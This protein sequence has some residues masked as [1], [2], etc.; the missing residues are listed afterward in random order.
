MGLM[1]WL[2]G[3]GRTE[4]SAGTGSAGAA[5]A[6]APRER[7]DLAELPPIQRMLGGQ[8]LVI[9][10]SGFQGALATRQDTSLGTPLGHLVSP[11]APTGLVHGITAPAPA[12]SPSPVQRSVERPGEPPVCTGYVPLSVPMPVQ[13]A[14]VSGAP[15]M[16]SAGESAVA[17]LPVRRLV[18]EQPLVTASGTGPVAES[19]GP[20]PVPASPVQRSAL[21]PAPDRARRAPGLGAPM[22]ALPPTAQRKAAH[23]GPETAGAGGGAGEVPGG[24]EAPEAAVFSAPSGVPESAPDTSGATAPLLGDSP[25]LPAAS[26]PVPA[27]PAPAVQRS[28]AVSFPGPLAPPRTSDPVAPLLAERPVALQ[29]GPGGGVGAVQRSAVD[30]AEAEAEAAAGVPSAGTGAVPGPS[31]YASPSAS[32]SGPPDSVPVRWTSDRAGVPSVTPAASLPAALQRTATAPAPG[33][34]ART[35]YP[36]RPALQRQA[37]G[38][39]PVPRSLPGSGSRSAPATASAPSVTSTSFTTAGSAAVAAGVAQRMADG[40]VVFGSPPPSYSAP[41]VQRETE[42]E[43]PPPPD[44]PQDAAPEPEPEPEPGPT[45]EAHG[46]PGA[47]G[48]APAHG[49]APVVTDELVRA[50]YAPLSRLFKADLRLERERAGF[51]INTRH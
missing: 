13:R 39:P 18:G 25:L 31:S 37:V 24:G 1:S 9:D 47:S 17:E 15:A 44:P 33:E 36:S 50:L 35:S 16:T 14:A 28:S 49:G 38:G 4:T 43:E 46:A 30:G 32:P 34:A 20:P 8:D 45:A 2:R 26:E 7:V 23:D 21:P 6:A 5:P 3:G 19:S 40:S 29:A 42:S 12:E 51:L 11:D 10:P 22:S 27:A 48:A 41:V